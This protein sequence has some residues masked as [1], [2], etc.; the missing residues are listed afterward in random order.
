MIYV[1]TTKN[2]YHRPL[3]TRDL[4]MSGAKS[5]DIILTLKDGSWMVI[6]REWLKKDGTIQR[7]HLKAIKKLRAA[8]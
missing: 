2:D 7:R 4:M 3:T 6:P 8:A 1:H 5:S